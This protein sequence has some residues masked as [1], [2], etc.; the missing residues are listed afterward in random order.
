MNELSS[1]NQIVLQNARKRAQL[2]RKILTEMGRNEYYSRCET[3]PQST[4]TSWA[5]SNLLF[6]IDY[7]TNES[8]SRN[9]RSKIDSN[10]HAPSRFS[11]TGDVAR[12]A[13]VTNISD[14]IEYFELFFTGEIE[15]HTVTETKCTDISE[16]NKECSFS[17][18]VVLTLSKPLLNKGYC[19][20]MDNYYNSPELGEMLLKSKTDFFGTLRLNKK[21]LL[22]ELKTRKL[23][24]GDLLAYHRGKMMTMRW[25]DKK[26]VHFISSIHNPEIVKVPN[27]LKNVEIEKPKIVF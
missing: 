9:L 3:F 10:S 8:Y 2:G 6:C 13:C 12:K 24:R 7:V 1:R 15:N 18:Q 22:K 14:P 19:L 26:Y 5:R 4:L 11:F 20:T 25:R 16:E 23:K 21:D 17:T 27:K